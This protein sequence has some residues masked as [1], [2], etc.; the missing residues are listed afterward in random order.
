MGGLKMSSWKLVPNPNLK[1]V[2]PSKLQ[3]ICHDKTPFLTIQ[4]SCGYQMHIHLSQIENIPQ[5]MIISRCHNCN[6]LLFFEKKW[7]L[8]AIQKAWGKK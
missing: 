8:E 4:C 6:Q 3:P 2:D 7:L 5:E 1:G